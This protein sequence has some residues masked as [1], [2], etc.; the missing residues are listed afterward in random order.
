MVSIYVSGD[1]RLMRKAIKQFDDSIIPEGLTQS[2]YPLYIKQIIP[3]Y[4]LFWIDMIYD[5]LMYRNDP[6][7]LKQFLLGIKSILA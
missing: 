6:D 2:R 3:P 7:F 5:Y 4:S 1:D